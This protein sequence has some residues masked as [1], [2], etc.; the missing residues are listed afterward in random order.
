MIVSTM[1]G[2]WL[3]ICYEKVHYSIMQLTAMPYTMETQLY[4][5][6]Q[7]TIMHGTAAE[8]GN[9]GIYVQYSITYVS[10]SVV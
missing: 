4:S 3:A 7:W 6:T 9:H 10:L 8:G 1:Q 2:G 5:V